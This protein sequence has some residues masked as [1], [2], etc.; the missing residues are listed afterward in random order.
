MLIDMALRDKRIMKTLADGTRKRIRLALNDT[1][2]YR[3]DTAAS[4]KL[5]ELACGEP[6]TVCEFSDTAIPPFRN[7]YIEIDYSRH[8]AHWDWHFKPDDKPASVM[9]FFYCG[10][11]VTY[12][13]GG[14]EQFA[15]FTPFAY[16]DTEK[17][18]T[19]LNVGITELFKFIRNE[20]E[21]TTLDKLKS[22]L[23]AGINPNHEK[24]EKIAPIARKLTSK[25][26]LGIAWDL[27]FIRPKDGKALADIL[28]SQAEECSGAMRIATACV[29]LL[30]QRR[31]TTTYEKRDGSK[32][33]HGKLTPSPSF[34]EVIIDLDVHHKTFHK[35]FSEG[36]KWRQRY[37]EV[38][39]YWT[40]YDC[41][42]QC[43]HQW[44]EYRSE[45]AE[46]RDLEKHGEILKRQICT[47]CGGRRTRK[48]EYTKGDIALGKVTKEYHVTASR[49][50][51]PK[52]EKP[53]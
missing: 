9:G 21:S 32:I 27:D 48:L 41:A 18:A 25:Y 29:L 19:L 45:S 36:P 16:I 5:F 51:R 17:V 14:D 24:F 2:R 34:H 37:H 13:I 28:T 44:V 23:I 46:K 7:T 1:K 33:I 47:L 4:D 50:R 53:K 43:Q 42:S 40:Y 12:I 30:N 20:E 38:S 31:V 3:F 10:D 15:Y 11:G 39:G 6:E 26:E 8:P 35:I 49:H 22:L 52:K